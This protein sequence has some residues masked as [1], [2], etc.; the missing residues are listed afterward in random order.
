MDKQT[1]PLA[2]IRVLELGRLIAAPFCG[3]ILGDLGADVI[4]VERAGAGDDIRGYGPPFLLNDASPG[5]ASSSYLAFNRNKRSIAID[6]SSP[7]GAELVRSLAAKCDVL[8]ENYKV[9]S[10]KKYGLD[11]ATIRGLY[12]N[13]IYLSVSGF[14]QKGPYAGRPATDV[15]VQGM[16]GI[17]SVTGEADRQPMK[18]G[19]PIADMTTGLYG[20]VAIISALYQSAKAGV[21]GRWIGV[22]LLDAAMTLLGIPASASHMTG[23]P[24]I[25]S[26]N[27]GVGNAPSGVFAC[28]DGEVLLQAG[29]D[30][31]FVKL[32][33]VLGLESVTQD[34]R[35]ALR[36][37]RVANYEQLRPVLNAAIA[38][39]S[40][41]DLYNA[42]VEAGIICG[43]INTID[44]AFEDPQVVTNGTYQPAGHPDDPNLKLITSPIRY[45][46]A[47]PGIRRYPPRMGEHTAEILREVL[48]M[49]PDAIAALG[50]K[51]IIGFSPEPA[52][53][54]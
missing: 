50:K 53:K 36:P 8:I 25:R 11:E 48:A 43:P 40:R 51:K 42:M 32:C 41:Q 27:D 15:A 22:S 12:P 47:V 31:D 14:G 18:V 6:F 2:G 39:W 7:D 16:S 44:Q 13:I 45:S 54:V 30:P 37:N 17:M 21:P 9:G 4:K 26:G 35:F 38:K 28:R 46:D 34:P 5:G 23:E 49:T 24:Q 3:Q 52:S 19:V 20:A 1:A 10:L 33:R 29:K